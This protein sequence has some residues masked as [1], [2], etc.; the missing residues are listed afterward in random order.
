MT[1]KQK[2]LTEE[3]RKEK[4]EKITSEV[5]TILDRMYKPIDIGEL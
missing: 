1:D 2:N 3:E 4:L 5:R